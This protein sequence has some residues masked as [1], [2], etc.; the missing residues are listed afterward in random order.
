MKH[1]HKLLYSLFSFCICGFSILS[2]NAAQ[3][4]GKLIQRDDGATDL[5]AEGWTWHL[6]KDGL[7]TTINTSWG[8]CANNHCITISS[9]TFSA[10]CIQYSNVAMLSLYESAFLSYG[11]TSGEAYTATKCIPNSQCETGR[12]ACN[13]NIYHKM[14]CSNGC[15][16]GYFY[17]STTNNCIVCPSYYTKQLGKAEVLRYGTTSGCAT[18]G[19]AIKSRCYI[20]NVTDGYNNSNGDRYSISNDHCFYSN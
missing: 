6:Y 8:V 10:A 4:C 3:K 7:P 15:T 19:N 9:D 5:Q 11:C 18:T 16:T 20:T 12:S 2:A 17:D 13:S 1:I 14:T